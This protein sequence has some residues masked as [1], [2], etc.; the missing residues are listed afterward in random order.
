[1]ATLEMRVRLTTPSAG[2][3]AVPKLREDVGAW[4]EQEARSRPQKRQDSSDDELPISATG[5]SSRRARKAA[6]P[7]R[8]DGQKMCHP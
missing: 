8:R 2:A 5:R 1:M 6:K 4:P 7:G 3:I